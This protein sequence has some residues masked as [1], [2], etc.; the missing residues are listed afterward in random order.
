MEEGGGARGGVNNKWFEISLLLFSA[1]FALLL[2]STIEGRCTD[3]CTCVRKRLPR[4]RCIGGAPCFFRE[5]G[6][7]FFG[8]LFK[9]KRSRTP[10]QTAA[11]CFQCFLL[12]T[13]WRA[14]CIGYLSNFFLF[15]VNLEGV[16]MNKSAMCGYFLLGQ[17][18]WSKATFYTA[19][20]CLC[21]LLR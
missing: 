17:L 8:R 18:I 15:L 21:T 3:T 13:M 7:S 19:G 11:G 14:M 12:R 16:G 9:G 4:R 1:E 2:Y 10:Q 5:S 6:A 20:V